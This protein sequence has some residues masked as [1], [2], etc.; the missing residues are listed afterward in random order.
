MRRKVIAKI[1][2]FPEG[3]RRFV[4]LFGVEI[5]IFK[6]HGNFY[7]L[8]NQC[9]HQGAELCRGSLNGTHLPSDPCEYRYG[10]D[11]QILRCPWHGWEFDITNGKAI[12]TP[13]KVRV[14]TYP[15]A[16]ESEGAEPGERPAVETYAVKEEDGWV[17]VYRS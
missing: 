11:Q 10:R 9:P 17:V 2:D 12:V 15:V 8:R 3:S 16:V 7:A 5:G 4:D 13:D 14:K 6:V 1:A